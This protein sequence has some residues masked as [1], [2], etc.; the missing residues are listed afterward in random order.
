[1]LSVI[2]PSC[3]LGRA[4]DPLS[5]L[6][7][8]VTAAAAEYVRPDYLD[9]RRSLDAMTVGHCL[10]ARIDSICLADLRRRRPFPLA[11][12][13]MARGHELWRPPHIAIS[14]LRANMLRS[15]RVLGPSP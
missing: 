13:Q 12:A 11:G 6:R 1:M 15:G 14:A 4:D 8:V 7:T 9:C 5:A 10:V 3:A 2:S